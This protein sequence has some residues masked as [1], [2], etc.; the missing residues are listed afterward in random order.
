MT[1]ART[2]QTNKKPLPTSALDGYDNYENESCEDPELFVFIMKNLSKGK[3]NM[4][5]AQRHRTS[6]H[7]A[8]GLGGGLALQKNRG[9]VLNT[10]TSDSDPKKALKDFERETY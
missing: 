7:H 5:M 4:R 1:S 8:A 10:M 6:W 9:Q 2:L 3:N